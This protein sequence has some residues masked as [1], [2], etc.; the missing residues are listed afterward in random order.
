VN[1]AV[2]ARQAIAENDLERLRE[3]LGNG[4]DTEDCNAGPWIVAGGR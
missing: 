3:F 4:H 1:R 2:T